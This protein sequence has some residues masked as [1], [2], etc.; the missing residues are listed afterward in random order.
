MAQVTG[1]LNAV[2]LDNVINSATGA[3]SEPIRLSAFIS[4]D[5][6]QTLSSASVTTTISSASDPRGDE[7]L[8][9]LD[10]PIVLSEGTQYFLRIETS[11]SPIAL[12]GANIANETDYDWSLPFRIDGYD[13]FGGLYRGDLNLQVY[14][15]DNA[16]KLARLKSILN[17]TD[18][19]FIPTNHQYA[20]IT[21]L[22]ERYPLTT[23]YYRELI[24]CPPDEDIIW[25]YRV[26]E[27]GMFTGRLGFELVKTFESYPTLGPLVIND[28]PA[29]EAFT[30]YDHPKVLVFKKTAEYSAAEVA[31]VWAQWT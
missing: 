26:A 16:D 15:D 31:A 14:W 30:F 23:V 21:R 25:C 2:E 18:Y 12:S 6:N 28:Q 1:A 3:V 17:Q 8:L 10:P 19:I 27:P 13:A 7:V 11:G 9:E 4:G 22:P 5:Q 20:Q 24:G 29:E